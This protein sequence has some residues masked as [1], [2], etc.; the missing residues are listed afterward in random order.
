MRTVFLKDRPAKKDRFGAHERI[1]ESIA[2][3]I[4]NGEEGKAISLMGTWGSGKSTIIELLKKKFVDNKKIAIFLYDAWE[5][6]KDP[7][8]RSYIEEF[9]AFL[10]DNQI[11]KEDQFKE[12]INR[13]KCN[14]EES[15]TESEP[16]INRYCKFIIMML[17]FVP[18]GLLLLKAGLENQQQILLFPQLEDIS[19]SIKMSSVYI[20]MILLLAPFLYTLNCI[21]KGK[22]VFNV[23]TKNFS[24]QTKSNTI[25]TFEP[26]ALEFKEIYGKLLHFATYN[27]TKIIAVIDNLDRVNRKKSW[28][29]GQQCR[30]FLR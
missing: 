5:H 21:R 28:T 9:H 4:D 2:T 3:M 20:G 7:I 1:A 15:E 16:K 23:F 18:L 14:V 22:D 29:F 17:Y 12:D 27:H 26:T 13:L 8:R 30:L 11:I 25:K 24:K 19:F 6:K 10:L